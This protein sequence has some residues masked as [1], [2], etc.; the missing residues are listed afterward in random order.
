V[1][2]KDDA[3]QGIVVRSLVRGGKT[4]FYAVNDTPW[5]TDLTIEFTS[6]TAFRLS[7][8]SSQRE[9]QSE[10][11]KDRTT[12]Q[13]S[14]E[15]FDLVGGETDSGQ[16]VIVDYRVRFPDAAGDSLRERVRDIRLR[17]NALRSPQPCPGPENASFELEPIGG[18]IP[19]WVHATGEGLEVNLDA[20]QGFRTSRSL[21]LVS[22]AGD[23]GKPA[24]V[25]W[26]R[27]APFAAPDTGRLSVVAWIKLADPTRQPTLRV[28]IEGKLDGQVYYRFGNIGAGERGR[29]A[30][31]L[32]TEWTM[33]RIPV[34]D[35]P[36]AGLTDL[37]VGFDLMGEGEVWIDEVQV[38][39][40]W[41]ED[42]ERDELLKSVAA[43]DVQLSSGQLAECQRFLD[44]YWPSFLRRNVTLAESRTGV[45]VNTPSD[46]PAG[47]PTSAPAAPEAAKKE[48]PSVMDRVRAW[49]SKSTSK[50]R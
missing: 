15:P 49:W 10:R 50:L 24:P 27:S 39:D 45:A 26:V 3:V 6:P 38:F 22:R 4:Y 42:G 1:R 30:K 2:P 40:L 13:V 46:T 47:T 16:A 28:A 25:V 23:G 29:P 32:S 31:P 5:P 41:F 14:L 12:W 37:R 36:L 19:G 17:A 33:A 44:G 43:A 35:L 9:A 48:D 34:P 20:Q 7:S 21:H 18:E 8:Y 11:Q